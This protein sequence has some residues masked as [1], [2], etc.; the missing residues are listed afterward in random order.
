MSHGKQTYT[1]MGYTTAFVFHRFIQMCVWCI[2]FKE[3]DAFVGYH[4]DVA[5]AVVFQASNQLRKR[6][7]SGREQLWESAWE[8][9]DHPLDQLAEEE[10]GS[11]A[12]K[13]MVIIHS[14][15]KLCTYDSA[16]RPIFGHFLFNFLV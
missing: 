16:L 5:A 14:G 3:S 12:W 9:R 2:R 6:V 8:R 15:C 10:E 1:G 7:T 13:N 4:K 11:E